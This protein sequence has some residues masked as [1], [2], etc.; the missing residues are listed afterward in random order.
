MPKNTKKAGRPR[1]EFDLTV[2]EGLGRIGATIDDMVHVLP[3][4]KRTIAERMAE[5][6]GD[7]RTAYEKGRSLLNSSLRRK[8]IQVAMTGNVAMLI[9]LGKQHLAQADRQDTRISVTPEEV[10]RMSDEEL[11]RMLEE[12]RLQSASGRGGSGR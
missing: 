5:P 1:I 6:E 12:A 11:T 9:W 4:S 3:A 10:A 2:V 8:Q 7:F